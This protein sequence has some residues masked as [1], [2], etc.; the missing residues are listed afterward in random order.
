[1]K[2]HKQASAATSATSAMCQIATPLL[3]LQAE[4]LRLK[5]PSPEPEEPPRKKRREKN[6]P[7]IPGFL[8]RL[9]SRLFCHTTGCG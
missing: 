8:Q 5:T 6:A 1:M 2:R 4:A 9:H 7:V 3:T